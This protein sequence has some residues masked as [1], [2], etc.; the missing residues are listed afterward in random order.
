MEI[1]NIDL[2][3]PTALRR[4]GAIVALLA[5]NLLILAAAKAAPAELG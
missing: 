4:G 1:M 2:M 5:C 3:P